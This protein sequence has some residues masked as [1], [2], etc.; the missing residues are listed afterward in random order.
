MSEHNHTILVGVAGGSA[1]GKGTVVD[2]LLAHYG[3]KAAV[4]R[5]DDYYKPIGQVPRDADGEPNFDEPDSLDLA[6]LAN[7]LDQLRAGEDLYIDSYTFNQPGVH[8]ERLHIPACPVVFLDGLFLL[9]D[10]GVRERLH[11]T[12]YIHATPETRL[13]RRMARDQA[14]R[15]LT[16]DII[17]YQWDRHVRPGDLAYLEPVSHL[18]HVAVDNDRLGE[19]DLSDVLAAISALTQS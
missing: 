4:L 10:A 8:S 7:D 3:A 11:L 15:S 14:E 17:Q 6:R 19:A 18:A 9:H 2:R 5:M 12:V 13:A 1:S 16:P